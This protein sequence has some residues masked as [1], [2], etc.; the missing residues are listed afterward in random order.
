LR[1]GERIVFDVTVSLECYRV[2]KLPIWRLAMGIWTSSC[3]SA[4][5]SLF[6]PA[7]AVRLGAIAAFIFLSVTLFAFAT[8]HNHVYDHSRP[9]KERYHRNQPDEPILYC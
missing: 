5:T 9:L 8:G 3:N 7:G 4:A 1:Q 2:A 6:V